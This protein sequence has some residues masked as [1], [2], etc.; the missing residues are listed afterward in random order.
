M[1]EKSDKNSAMPRP[2]LKEFGKFA[3]EALSVGKNRK[4]QS[5]NEDRWVATENTLAVID[6][7]TPRIPVNLGGKSGAQFVADLIKDALINS[8]PSINGVEL[9]RLIT[10]RLNESFDEL[11]VQKQL[12]KT[13]ETRPA[14]AFAAVRIDGKKVVITQIADVGVRINSQKLYL[15]ELDV[16]KAMARLRIEAMQK[17]KE[18][19]PS[20][21]DEDLLILGRNAIGANLKEQVTKYWNN[22]DLDLGHGI[23]DGRNVPDKF[24]KTAEFDLAS[25]ESLE[26]FSD[27]YFKIPKEVSIAAWEKA[28][29]EVESE[30]PLKWTTYPSTKGS[31]ANQFSDDRTILIARFK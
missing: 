16:D 22:P 7:A 15:E 4:E 19:N 12:E 26:I 31:N 11:G 25:M 9:V 3:V 10:K 5:L 14:A 21:S 24:I 17:A 30:D 2:E 18:E 1:E 8:D 20:V 28:F 29:E 23:I 13:P 27:G 6:G